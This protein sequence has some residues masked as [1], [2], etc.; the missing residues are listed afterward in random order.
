METLAFIHLA[1]T[2]ELPTD[3]FVCEGVDWRKFSSQALLYLLPV[4]SMIFGILGMANEVLAQQA[5]R[6]DSG[7]DVT[8][9]QGRLR[10]LGHFRQEPTGFF[11]LITE[12]AVKEFQEVNGLRVD[13]IVGSETEALLFQLLGQ[14]PPPPIPLIPNIGNK[15]TDPS[16][17]RTVL[18]RGN[19][20]EDVKQLQRELRK[21]GFDPGEIDGIYGKLT[22][23][24][25][26][27]FQ[28]A[29]GLTADGVADKQTLQALGILEPDDK[30][31]V[32]VIPGDY[33]TLVQVQQ[34]R[35]NARPDEDRRGSYVNAGSFDNRNEAESLS[36]LLQVLGFDARV[37]YF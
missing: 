17:S 30:R 3:A 4:I 6:G 15:P 8:L 18:R 19:R 36:H 34:Y 2:D 25:V 28:R 11:G 35:S 21:N 13:G 7:N 22:E 1:L 37:E 12:S 32:V 33:N 10:Q 9:I 20:G 16:N 27:R 24:A 5:S 29:K 14:L 23:S 31:Y 26:L